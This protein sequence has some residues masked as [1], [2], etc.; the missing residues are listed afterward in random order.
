[1]GLNNGFGRSRMPLHC[2]FPESDESHVADM[3]TSITDEKRIIG[4][5]KLLQTS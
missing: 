5:K 3:A 1:V 2:K 4:R